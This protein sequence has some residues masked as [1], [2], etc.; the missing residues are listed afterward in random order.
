MAEI[1]YYVLDS[2]TSGLST[3]I[4]EMTEISIIRVSDR[5]QLTEF[6]KC[7]H[8]NSCNADALIKT[9]RTMED[10]NKGKSKEEVVDKVIKFMNEDGLTPAFRCIIAHN[11]S[12][13]RR[14][15]KALFDKCNKRFPAD[16]W[17]CTMALTVKY[18]KQSNIK[19]L[20]NLKAACENLGVKRIA[21]NEHTAKIDTRNAYLLYKALIDKNVDYIPLIVNDPH[22]VIENEEECG[23]DPALLDDD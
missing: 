6:I 14:F 23:L 8:P 15:L 4:H 17:L 10:L 22:M 13:D 1:Q 7:E 18:Y 2:E 5:I 12:F 21:G 9:G 3:D 20:K 16:L 11:A 19:A